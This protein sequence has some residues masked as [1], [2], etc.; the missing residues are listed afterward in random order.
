MKTTSFSFFLIF[1]IIIH[2]FAWEASAAGHDL[3]TQAFLQCLSRNHTISTITYTPNNSSYST[4]LNSTIRNARFTLP[5]TPKPLAIITP[6]LEYQVQPVIYCSTKHDVQ[7][8]VRSGGHDYEGQSFTSQG[9]PFV[10]IDLINLSSIHVDAAAATA[11][12]QSGATIG[13]LYYN[14]AEKSRTLAFPAG[15]WHSIGVGGHL[16]GGGQGTL[17]R[18]YGLSADNIVDARLI[19]VDGRI[20]DRK[21]MGEDLFWAIRGSGGASF[22]V[23]LAWKVKLVPVPESVTVFT[24]TKTRTEN[25]KENN[26]TTS[27]TRLIHR[28]QHVADKLH[29]DL[30]IRII[31]NRGVCYFNSFF[32]GGVDRLLPIMQESFP[33]LGLVAKDCTEM[34]WIDSVYYFSGLVRGGPLQGLLNTTST[35]SLKRYFKGKSDYVTKPIPIE[36]IERLWDFLD[37]PEART[38]GWAFTPYGGRMS[39]ISQSE[40]PFPHRSGNIYSIDH[41]MYWIDEG[42]EESKRHMNWVRKVYKFMA[43]YVSNSPRAA[44]INYKDLDLGV[45]NKKGNT[46]YSRAS[47]WGK[48]YFKNNFPRLAQVKTM[49]DPTNFFRNEQSIPLLNYKH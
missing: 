11:W 21:T 1:A 48:K 27:A 23:I 45:N 44:Y 33:E 43:H 35:P 15:T 38:A 37:E 39:R 42:K 9:D 8:R 17:V 46:S 5:S 32:V 47:V 26:T 28:W 40:I 41:M 3:K 31:I 19:G 4:I 16:S 22:G 30:F 7:I 20:L 18:K 24:I 10:L 49:V 2:H 13:Q 14:I 34:S 12:V 36:A 29:R 25:N 6:S